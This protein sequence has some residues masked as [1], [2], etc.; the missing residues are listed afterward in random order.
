MWVNLDWTFKNQLT[1]Q[2]TH[3]Y[4]DYPAKMI[5][6]IAN[7]LFKMYAV[8]NGVVLDPYC[9]SGTTLVEA[10]RHE[11]KAFGFDLNPLAR[12][13]AQT[14]TYKLDVDKLKLLIKKFDEL[15]NLKPNGEKIPDNFKIDGISDVNFWFKSP[16]IEKLISIKEFVFNIDDPKLRDFFKV[17]FSETVRE[18]S[19]TRKNEF[20]LYRYAP[21][22]LEKHNPDPYKIMTEKI[23]RNFQSYLDMEM[24]MSERTW[25]EATVL[26][27]NSCLGIPNT[28]L[29]E[30]SIDLIVTSPPYGD[31]KTTVAY[32]QYSRLSSAWLEFLKPEQVDNKLMG[33]R[34]KNIEKLPSKKLNKCISEILSIDEQRAKE[35]FSFYKDLFDSISNV[36]KLIKNNGYVCYVVGNRTVKGVMLPTDEIVKDFF[37]ESG[38]KYVL[39][40]VREI[41]NK[42]MPLKNSPSNQ[43]GKTAN[44][45]LNEYIVVMK[46]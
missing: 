15:I 45:M 22:K 6:P 8:K 44:T 10:V 31:S 2:Y 30:G 9:G 11:M 7:Q 34:K 29:N 28:M 35:V 3:S 23:K 14:K 27:F 19:N 38:L 26:D 13:I 16:V 33:G 21:E 24:F 32:G 25:Y 18:S 37:L 39:T 46:K 1:K 12:L 20:K 5:F 43:V 40:Y 17:A 42:R 4:H 41:P 36:S